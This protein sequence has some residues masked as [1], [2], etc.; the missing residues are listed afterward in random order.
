MKITRSDYIVISKAI[1]RKLYSCG[2]WGTGSLYEDNLKKGFPSEEKG[3]VLAV[4][5]ALVKQ[6]I[7]CK[8]RKLYGFKYYLNTAKRDKIRQIL[9][10]Q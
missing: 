2:C 1:L 4:V 9:S 6:G 8:K 3:K 7:I 10:I 5:D